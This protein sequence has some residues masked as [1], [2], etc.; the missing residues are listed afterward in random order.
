MQGV[1]LMAPA[2]DISELW[3]DNMSAEEQREGRASGFV[4]LRNS[5]EVTFP[6]LIP[7]SLAL[8]CVVTTPLP[9]C[10]LQT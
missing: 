8:A 5:T 6:L 3:W 1:V 7:M 4:P 10:K 9:P 2:V